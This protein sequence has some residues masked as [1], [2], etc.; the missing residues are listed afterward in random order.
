MAS[1][2]KRLLSGKN[3]RQVRRLFAHS[4]LKFRSLYCR[5][6]KFFERT[7]L[8]YINKQWI[9]SFRLERIINQS[10]LPFQ[11]IKDTV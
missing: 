6:T 10:L 2:V 3:F 8:K 7:F 5:R 4:D 1:S 11:R 9:C